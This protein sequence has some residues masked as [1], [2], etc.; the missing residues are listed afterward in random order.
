LN[1]KISGIIA[2]AMTADPLLS[3]VL[4]V[5]TEEMETLDH[6]KRTYSRGAEIAIHAV[7]YKMAGRNLA[8]YVPYSFRQGD[9]S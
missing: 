1:I 9:K 3:E 2:E 4:P 6:A 8:T 7:R 5:T